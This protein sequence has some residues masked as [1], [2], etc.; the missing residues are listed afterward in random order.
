MFTVIFALSYSSSQE[1][2]I[3]EGILKDIEKIYSISKGE[4]LIVTDKEL[5]FANNVIYL[6]MASDLEYFYERLSQIKDSH[7][8]FYC[9]LHGKERSFYL[10]DKTLIPIE[11]FFKS[12]LETWKEK[13]KIFFLDCCYPFNLSL[14]F[15]YSKNY[16]KLQPGSSVNWQNKKLIV[17]TSEEQEV[18]FITNFSGSKLTNDFIYFLKTKNSSQPGIKFYSAHLHPYLLPEW[19]L[20]SLNL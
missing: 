4:K 7:I 5:K 14:P 11:V 16:W 6:K 15:S 1:L 12:I 13:E 10:P 8:F 20:Q 2:N 19:F 18:N 9:S 3:A 17:I